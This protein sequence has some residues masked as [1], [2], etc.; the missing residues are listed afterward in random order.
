MSEKNIQLLLTGNELM[1]GDIVDSNSV[2][3][4]HLLSNIGLHISRKVT[5]G[6]DINLLINEIEHITQSADIL[7]INGGLGPTIDD[8]TAQAVATASKAEL[9]ENVEALNHLTAWCEKRGVNL[10]ESNLKQTILPS[11]A[12]IIANPIGSAVGFRL[13]INQCDIYCT[14]GVPKELALMAEQEI[15]PQLKLTTS[16]QSFYLVRRFLVF[17]IG[18]A[19]LQEILDNTFPDWPSE[20]ELG[21]RASSPMLE[22]KLTINHQS[23]EPLLS[24]WIDI[25]KALLGEHILKEIKGTSASMAELVIELLRQ[26][27]KKITTVESCTGGL[28]SSELTGVSGASNVFE[29]GFVTYSNKIKSTMVDV[30]PITLEKFGAVSEQVVLEMAKGGLAYSEADFVIA[31][32]GIAGPKGGTLEKPVGSV[33]IAWGTK[34]QLYSQY[35]CIKGNRE[36][37][38]KMT[39][40][41]ALDLIRRQL[42]GSTET[43]NY[44]NK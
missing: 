26:K 1:S 22:L 37:F 13:S 9:K 41:R 19:K 35:F 28:I 20:I 30:S 38:Q 2:M 16:E 23:N 15:I 29:A 44:I 32:S 36:Y 34:N 24:S 33:W 21:F 39:S 14:P 5:V 17:G 25:I 27:N 6:D 11:N 40:T 3:I 12:D 8:M 4:A 18:E 43:P 31:V 7:I 42:L 10:S